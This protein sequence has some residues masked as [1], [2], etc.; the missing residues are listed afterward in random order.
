MSEWMIIAMIVFAIYI[1]ARGGLLNCF[2]ESNDSS[3]TR[4]SPDLRVVHHHVVPYEDSCQYI[5]ELNPP[6]QRPIDQPRESQAVWNPQVNGLV[7]EVP[8]AFPGEP[9]PEL[10]SPGVPEIPKPEQWTL[11]ADPVVAPVF[12]NPGFP[13][14]PPHAVGSWARP[15]ST[16]PLDP[17]PGALGDAKARKDAQERLL[18]PNK[19]T[20]SH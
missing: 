1:V 9:N 13:I 14:H 7:Y 11:D 3:D 10:P 12:E 19:F 16:G 2:L 6:N 18:C 5:Q 8:E 20:G 15:I 17:V 4:A